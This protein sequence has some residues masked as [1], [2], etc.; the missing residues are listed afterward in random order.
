MQWW[1]KS[2][3]VCAAMLLAGG[4]SAQDKNIGVTTSVVKEVH[5]ELGAR[6][7]Q[8]ALADPVYAQELIKTRQ[9]SASQLKFLD[10]TV[11]TVG[12]N[13]E[14]VLDN[15]VYDA[16]PDQQNV[17]LNASVGVVRF[18]TGKLKSTAYRIQTPT[19]T[20]GVRGTVFCIIIAPDGSS[21]IVVYD[22]SVRVRN[23]S[24]GPDSPEVTVGEGQSTTVAP[25]QPPSPPGPPSLQAQAIIAQMDA[26]LE[27]GSGTGAANPLAENGLVGFIQ[28]AQELRVTYR[29]G[30]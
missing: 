24:L 14:V 30:C 26:V 27:I 23:L 21:E 28:D 15:F 10:D 16:A 12:P 5:A 7:R 29:C 9:D 18:V 8:L 11:L 17:V 3:L 25:G 2:V 20:I 6:D 1:G 13:S 19:A 4:V 22:G